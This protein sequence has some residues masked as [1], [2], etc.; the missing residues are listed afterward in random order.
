[1]SFLAPTP[2]AAP[3]A[4]PPPP[5]PPIMADSSVKAAGQA[6]RAAAAAANG[7]LGFGGTVKT[8]SAGAEPP[9]TSKKEL[10]GQ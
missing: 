8:S 7:D 10:L 9:A 5:P 3:A 4:P 6:A 1:M 2:Q